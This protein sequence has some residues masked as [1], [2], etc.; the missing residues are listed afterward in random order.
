MFELFLSLKNKEC[1]LMSQEYN[2]FY[3][4]KSL[5]LCFQYIQVKQYHSLNIKP[6]S[7]NQVNPEYLSLNQTDLIFASQIILALTNY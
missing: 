3:Y 4:V 6:A 7:T 2:D 1:Y 5:I